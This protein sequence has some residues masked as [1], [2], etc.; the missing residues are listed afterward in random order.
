[1]DA[2]SFH[3]LWFLLVIFSTIMVFVSFYERKR[4]TSNIQK[5]STKIYVQ[6]C[7]IAFWG[8]LLLVAL[9]K[10]GYLQ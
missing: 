2:I 3:P 6:C 10:V 7:L 1:M 8:F 5:T 9:D 4:V